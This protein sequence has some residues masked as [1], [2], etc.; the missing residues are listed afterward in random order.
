[1]KKNGKTKNM[2]SWRKLLEMLKKIG[3]ILLF[4]SHVIRLVKKIYWT[5]KEKMD[6]K[7]TISISLPLVK[8][9]KKQRSS[10]PKNKIFY[11]I[12]FSEINFRIR[13]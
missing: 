1:M 3:N 5:V 13:F 6:I 12:G 9:I 2:N 8:R 10:S 11:K 4:R 7:T